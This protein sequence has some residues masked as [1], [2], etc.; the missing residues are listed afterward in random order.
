MGIARFEDIQGWQ[1][2]RQLTDAIYAATRAPAFSKDWELR[3]QICAASGSAMHNIAEGFDSSSNR[4]FS[5]F[6]TYA[7]RSCTEVQ[8][9]L[10]IALD[11]SYISAV[12]FQKLF[13]LAQQTKATIGG[14]IKY[15]KQHPHPA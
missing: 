2:A 6:L 4:E 13:D 5:K 15:L 7:Q 14:F 1:L 8:S 10:Y 11:Q 3:N 9:Q 12:E